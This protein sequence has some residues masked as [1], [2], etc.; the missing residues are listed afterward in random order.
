MP[1]ISKRRLLLEPPAPRQTMTIMT[2]ARKVSFEESPMSSSQQLNAPHS[3]VSTCSMPRTSWR[4][5]LNQTRNQLTRRP[6]LSVC[7]SE[8]TS[9]QEV[10]PE[11]RQ[12]FDSPVSVSGSEDSC[13]IWGQFVDVIPEDEDDSQSCH[14]GTTLFTGSSSLHSFQPYYKPKRTHIPKCSFI[15]SIHQKIS[16]TTDGVEEALR[17][18]QV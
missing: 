3:P 15:L 1:K 14:V 2:Q 13:S 9:S 17:R 12:R 10:T 18:M 8:M 7:L 4:R 5:N 16:T 11:D 6:T